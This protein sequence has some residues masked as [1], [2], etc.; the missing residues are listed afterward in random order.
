MLINTLVMLNV[1]GFGAEKLLVQ[2]SL[3]TSWSISAAYDRLPF[4]FWFL[5]PTS[6]DKFA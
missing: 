2:L 5:C 1:F 6:R 3:P 4:E